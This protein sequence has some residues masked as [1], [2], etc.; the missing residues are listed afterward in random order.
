MQ[1]FNQVVDFVK[2]PQFYY[3]A[4]GGL[5][6]L[7]L[8]YFLFKKKSTSSSGTLDNLIKNFLSIVIVGVLTLQ[9]VLGTRK[10]NADKR[11]K[12][13]IDDNEDRQKELNSIKEGIEGEISDKKK[14]IQDIEDE[15][16]KIEEEK[17]NIKKEKKK[18]T[19]SIEDI[20]KKLKNL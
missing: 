10:N 17:N 15:I 20:S 1:I 19:K 12:E 13:D 5:L 8:L 11:I 18:T 2:Q 6:I 3:Y 16:N 9:I 4:G 14:S 7:I